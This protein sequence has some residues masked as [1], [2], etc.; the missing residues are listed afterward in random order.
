MK[1]ETRKVLVERE[2]Y[3]ASDGTEFDDENECEGYEMR[4]I[5]EQMLFFDSEFRRT[6][7]ERCAYA[8]LRT[9]EEVKQFKHVCDYMGYA[10]RGLNQS[11]VYMYSESDDRW[12]NLYEV[13]E[14]IERVM[15]DEQKTTR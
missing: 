12:L 8:V 7:I 5:E 14:N 11:G 4:L 10:D 13:M 2:V 15:R 1:I 9:D 3:I 6:V